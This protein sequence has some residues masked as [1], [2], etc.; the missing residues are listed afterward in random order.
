MAALYARTGLEE[1]TEKMQANKTRLLSEL[2]EMK[3]D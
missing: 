1:L 2:K 3:L